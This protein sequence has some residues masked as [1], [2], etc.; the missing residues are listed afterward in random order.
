MISGHKN[1]SYDHI[2]KANAI[3]HVFLP[4]EK[5]LNA[6]PA[7]KQKLSYLQQVECNNHIVGGVINLYSRPDTSWLTASIKLGYRYACVWFDGCYPAND[8]FN[9]QVLNDIDQYNKQETWF[10]AGNVVNGNFDQ[11]MFIVNL[12]AWKE[13]SNSASAFAGIE[14]IDSNIFGKGWIDVSN[15]RNLKIPSITEELDNTI[16]SLRP[17][18]NPAEFIK[19]LEGNE[20]NKDA[21]SYQ[22]NSMIERIFSPDSPVFFVNTE[23]TKQKVASMDETHF[24]QYVGPTAGFKLLYYAYKYGIEP[25]LTR[26]VFFDFDEHSC[27]FKRDTLTNWN[28]EDYVAWVNEWCEKN[29]S[30]NDDLKEMVAKRW[31]K[32]VDQFGGKESWLEFW[33]K[34]RQCEVDV[35]QCDLINDHAKLFSQLYTVPTLLW[36]SNIYSYIIP[37]LLAQP[38]Q[39]ERSFIEL[40]SSLSEL[41][42]D[43]W[44]SG[45][46][47]NDTDLMCP[48]SAIRTVGDNSTLGF[49]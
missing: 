42:E 28:G 8:E 14:D 41:S 48:V 34:V 27:K 16:T 44:F 30:A 15:K 29:P 9:L 18:T 32:V 12:H 37:V 20:Y 6:E 19:G 21:L 26:F 7:L 36:T 23:N 4:T 31:P 1:W 22:A 24:M 47:I 43:S 38:F 5:T 13:L 46:D 11:S 25:G 35:I 49:E 39:L 33:N 40:I 2:G 17:H 3:V 45:T 10:V